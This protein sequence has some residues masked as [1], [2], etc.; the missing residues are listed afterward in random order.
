MSE[1]L[2]PDTQRHIQVLRRYMLAMESG[3]ADCMATV[4]H[5]AEQDRA[6]ERMILE[7]NDFYQ[8]EDHTLADPTDVALVQQFLLNTIPAM[9]EYETVGTSIQSW[10][11]KVSPVYAQSPVMLET[12]SEPEKTPGTVHQQTSKRLQARKAPTQVLPS[13]K[14]APQKW[15]QTRRNWILAAIAAV[16]VALL[17]LPNS[18]ALASQILSFFR[19][20]QFQPVQVT[21]QEVQTLSSRPIP[22]FEDLGTLQIQPDSLQTH[23]NL[24]GAQ[25]ARMVNFPILLPTSLPRGIPGTPDFSVIDAGHATFTFSANKAHAFFVKNGYG[26]V[27]IPA[28]LDGST[29]DI[30]TTAGVVIAY[31]NQAAAQFMVVEVPSPV[32][33][34]T[35]NASIQELRDVAL[36]LPGLPPQL[37]AQLRQIDLNSG[38]VP[39]PIPTGVNSR[40]ITVHGTSGLLLTSNISTTIE[41]L[42]KFPAGSAVVWQ[43]H[44]IIYA[45]GGTISDTNQLLISANSLR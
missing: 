4:L 31:G 27:N 3:D 40:S 18:G 39:L 21:K 44:G 17:L 2:T 26:N 8:Q 1:Q 22:T 41:Q 36:S 9:R 34:A 13:K 23:E 25:A 14:I 19:V 11:S 37:V 38:V 42:K 15:Y 24:T 16:L 6:L 43:T 33:R 10:D 12:V 28:N 35:G 45:L 29:F 5:E 20:Q 32:V 7:V 30:T